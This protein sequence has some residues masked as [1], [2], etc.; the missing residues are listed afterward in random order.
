MQPPGR[1]S[2]NLLL[3]LSH[4]VMSDPLWPHGLQH[5]RLLCPWISQARILSGLP[6]PS[7]GNLPNP[8]TEPL[9]PV[10]PVSPVLAGRFF[11]TEPPKSSC[12]KPIGWTFPLPVS[13]PQSSLLF[14]G[15][16]L[17]N[18]WE[19]CLILLCFPE[20]VFKKRKIEG[21]WQHC[22]EPVYWYPLF[23][24]PLLVCILVSHFGNLHNISNVCIIILFFLVLCPLW[25]YYCK[26][27]TAYWRL[28]WLLVSF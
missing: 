25:C 14:L 21:L 27:I 8:G 16:S 13:L 26:N 3:L 28:R 1:L 6:F 2:S 22:M 23:Q 10:S 18:K 19:A 11:I 7:P 15:I 17:Q 24:Q 9:S 4:S 12:P 5:A 20:T